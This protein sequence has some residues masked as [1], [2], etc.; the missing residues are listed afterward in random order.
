[1][2]STDASPCS[3]SAPVAYTPA[4]PEPTTA[5]R[6]MTP[7]CRVSAVFRTGPAAPDSA[8]GSAGWGW[9]GHPAAR[10][11]HEGG[12]VQSV[13]RT[14]AVVVPCEPFG[15]PLDEAHGAGVVAAGS[16]RE[17]DTDLG[18]ALPE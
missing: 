17:P 5:T 13:R 14:A 2:T 6:S 16:V 11:A 15:R 3:V 1:M 18:Q 4:G 7:V 12:Q 8:P 10:A 9:W